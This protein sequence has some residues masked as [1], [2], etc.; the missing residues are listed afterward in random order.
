MPH[1][2]GIA[3][4]L[5]NAKVQRQKRQAKKQLESEHKRQKSA[6]ALEKERREEGMSKPLDATNKGFH[7][8]SKMGYKPGDGLGKVGGRVEPVGIEIMK[9]KS[10]LGMATREKEEE[11][12]REQRSIELMRRRTKNEAHMQTD[13]QARM[14]RQ[15]QVAT[16]TRDLHTSCQ[17]CEQLDLQVGLAR[18]VFWCSPYLENTAHHTRS[19]EDSQT[20][21]GGQTCTVVGKLFDPRRE[22]WLRLV[23][24]SDDADTIALNT[25]AGALD[26]S[27]GMNSSGRLTFGGKRLD[28][29]QVGVVEGIGMTGVDDYSLVRRDCFG[30]GREKA[31]IVSGQCIG[32]QDLETSGHTQDGTSSIDKKGDE[33]GVTSANT[34]DISTASITVHT[35]SGAD[36]Q[37]TSMSTTGIGTE[38]AEET[39][40][41]GVEGELVTARDV[42]GLGE[43]KGGSSTEPFA[44]GSLDELRA[45]WLVDVTKYLR[46]KHLYCNWCGRTYENETLLDT[47]C[48]GPTAEDHAD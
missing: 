1:L 27:V 43:A 45:Q 48:P 29:N 32:V 28:I 18:T 7:M 38:Q 14:R 41:V 13:F 35:N 4:R 22:V 44:G 47:Q 24:M 25:Y 26:M 23:V 21:Y 11:Q 34:A 20:L 37:G 46:S 2:Y 5:G 19:T 31:H 39:V 9:P 40:V 12:R 30:R 33:R 3:G 16:T 15:R 17:V 8:L 10:G 6:S 36:M 42:L